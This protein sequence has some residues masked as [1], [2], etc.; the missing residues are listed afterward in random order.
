MKMMTLHGCIHA[1]CPNL[2]LRSPFNHLPDAHLCSLVIVHP[3][4]R[5]ADSVNDVG[6]EGEEFSLAPAEK[7]LQ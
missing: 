6:E 7:K 3:G 1:G 2:D 5:F 4:V